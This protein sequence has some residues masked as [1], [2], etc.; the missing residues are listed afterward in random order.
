MRR[1]LLA[2]LVVA[3]C[4]TV[5]DK[6]KLPA[7]GDVTTPEHTVAILQYGC[8]NECWSTLYDLMSE[9]TRDKYSYVTFRVGFPGLKPPDREE[10]VHELVART[11][12]VLVSRSHLGDNYRLAYLTY[13]QGGESKDL[14]VL[15][16]QE[17]AEWHVALEEQVEK[18]VAFE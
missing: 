15:L 7:G 13:K 5:C 17:G 8:R 6:E 3:G 11:N 9:K 1:F 12:E 2:L 14:N 18:K 4:S 16:I 10:T